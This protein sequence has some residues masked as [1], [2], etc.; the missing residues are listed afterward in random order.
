MLLA[1][2]LGERSKLPVVPFSWSKVRD[3]F[4]HGNAHIKERIQENHRT[5]KLQ[6]AFLSV[7]LWGPALLKELTGKEHLLVDGL[8]RQHLEAQMFDSLLEF[9]GREPVYVLHFDVPNEIARNR[10]VGRGQ[11]QD[12]SPDAISERLAWYESDAFP[13]LDFFRQSPRYYVADIDASRSQEEVLSQIIKC[14]P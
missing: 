5:G 2:H 6:P 7:S 12:R 10:L 9:Y 11:S 13:L 14:L 3:E 4:M 8:P 1:E